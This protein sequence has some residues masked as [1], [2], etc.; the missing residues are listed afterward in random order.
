MIGIDTN[1]L[2]R[3]T[4]QDDDIQTKQALA[5]A[6]S[7]TQDQPGFVNSAVL[8]EFIWTARRQVK[9]SKEELKIILSGFLDSE[10]LVLEDENVI[11]LTLDEMD[12]SN[13]EFADIFIAFK[14]RELGCRTT[15]TFD[16]KAARTVPHMELLT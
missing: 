9:M 1:I 11:E 10:N 13:E 3:L 8:L 12:R 2:L 5:L 4:M 16:R 15:M 6:D 7:L 14:N